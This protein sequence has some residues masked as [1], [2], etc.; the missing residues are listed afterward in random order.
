MP[1][2]NLR[3]LRFSYTRWC[4]TIFVKQPLPLIGV[5]TFLRCCVLQHLVQASLFLPQYAE[6]ACLL[7][8]PFHHTPAYSTLL[9]S[10]LIHPGSHNFRLCHLL[11]KQLQG[12]VANF[13]K[14]LAVNSTVFHPG[15]RILVSCCHSYQ[16]HLCCG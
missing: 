5:H 10:F 1:R 4:V 11:R 3:E 9:V 13:F 8:A 12:R 2:I 14:S 16:A 15:F 7:V 6:P